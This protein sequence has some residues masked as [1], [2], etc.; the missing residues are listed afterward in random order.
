MC[1]PTLDPSSNSSLGP[2]NMKGLMMLLPTAQYLGAP[3]SRDGSVDCCCRTWWG[4]DSLRQSKMSCPTHSSGGSRQFGST[5]LWIQRREIFLQWYYLVS[6][7]MNL[8]KLWGIVED[9]EAWYDVVHGV[10][11]RWNNLT[12]EQH[13]SVILTLGVNI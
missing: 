6:M 2:T 13:L 11:K 9:R 12:T 1:L 3:C 8:S 7:D 4:R 5:V 10:A